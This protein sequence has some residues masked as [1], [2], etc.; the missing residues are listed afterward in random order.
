M[1]IVAAVVALVACVHAGLWALTQSRVDAPAFDG[2]L[3][4]ISYAP[5]AAGAHPDTDLASVAQIRS[6]LKLLAP[7]TRGLRTYSS[8]AGVDLVPAVAG[9]FGLKVT[10]GA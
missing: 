8:T 1:R 3:A 2:Q 10:V 6:D 5:Y 4:S 7:Y 9:E